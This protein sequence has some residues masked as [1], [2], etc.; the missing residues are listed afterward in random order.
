MRSPPFPPRLVASVGEYAFVTRCMIPNAVWGRDAWL[1][2]VLTAMV[3]TA[4]VV[5]DLGVIKRHY[6]FSAEVE[7]AIFVVGQLPLTQSQCACS[8]RR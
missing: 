3:A 5:S 2:P 7:T 6:G 1:R 4:E 8:R